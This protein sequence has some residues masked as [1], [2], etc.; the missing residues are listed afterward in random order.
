VFGY[1]RRRRQAI[2]TLKYADDL[3]LMSKEETML[4]GTISRVIEM[5]RGLGM[6]MDV[7]QLGQ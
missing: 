4:R 2:R 7:E 3:V 1:F 6:Q 5:G